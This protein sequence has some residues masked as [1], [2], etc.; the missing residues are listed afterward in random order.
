MGL[1]CVIEGVET[2]DQVAVVRALGGSLVQGYLF[3]VPIQPADIARYLAELQ[4]PHLL[5]AR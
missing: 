4:K 3:S 5:D 1:D 2:Q